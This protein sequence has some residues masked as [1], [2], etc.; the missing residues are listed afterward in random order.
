MHKILEVGSLRKLIPAL[1]AAVA[2]ITLVT[3]NVVCAADDSEAEPI[4]A[5][6]VNILAGESIIVSRFQD[7]IHGGRPYELAWAFSVIVK[8]ARNP[9]ADFVQLA[10]GG[11]YYGLI[12]LRRLDRAKYRAELE[13]FSGSP[14]V[15]IVTADSF[16]DMSAEDFVRHDLESYG[17][18]MY[19]KL[20]FTK[21][22]RWEDTVKVA[23]AIRD[24]KASLL[25]GSKLGRQ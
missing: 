15:R 24:R 4:V 16:V 3:G 18:A 7:D 19:G 6:A 13:A 17:D 10:R 23:V 11:S 9:V 25:D 2:V 14:E 5:K 1:F 8:K 22:P 12:G 20:M 21:L